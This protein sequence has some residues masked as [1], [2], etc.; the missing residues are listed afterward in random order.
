[1]PFPQRVPDP[2]DSRRPLHLGVNRQ[3]PSPGW[4]AAGTRDPGVYGAVRA[5]LGNRVDQQRL[6]GTHEFREWAH[7]FRGEISPIPWQDIL[8]AQGKPE[9]IA[10]VE[11]DEA[12][13]QTFDDVFGPDS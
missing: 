10:V 13:R 6:E 12:A 3:G 5:T 1:M 11:R 2:Q 4:A 8:L 7:H 9:M